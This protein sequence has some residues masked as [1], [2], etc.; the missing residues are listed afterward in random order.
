M[1]CF[2]VIFLFYF[3]GALLSKK[4]FP[5]ISAPSYLTRKTRPYVKLSPNGRL[6]GFKKVCWIVW[7]PFKRL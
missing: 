5:K 6:M 3:N 1:L 7:A 2:K 4:N